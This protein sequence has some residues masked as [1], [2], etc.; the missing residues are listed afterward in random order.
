[1]TTVGGIPGIGKLDWGSHLCQFFRSRVELVESLV[2]YY[3][4]GL[5]NNEFC[6]MGTAA[7]FY[8][9][10]VQPE[11]AKA[12]PDLKDRIQRGQMLIFDH[13]DWYFGSRSGDAIGDL[14]AAEQRALS[15][16]YQGLRC[17]G[18]ISWITRKDWPGFLDYE[19]RVSREIRDRRIVALCSYDVVRCEGGEVIDASHAHHYTVNRPSGGWELFEMANRSPRTE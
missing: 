17:G 19:R 7:P 2:S 8:A 5:R 6:L 1:M 9:N 3:A 14:L 18:N 13:H 16:G 12:V 15:A 4:A 10:E 11:L